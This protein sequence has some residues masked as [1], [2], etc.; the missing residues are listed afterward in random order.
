MS[1]DEAAF[2]SS[3]ELPVPSAEPKIQAT[4]RNV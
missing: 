4:S 2:Y 1:K 3:W